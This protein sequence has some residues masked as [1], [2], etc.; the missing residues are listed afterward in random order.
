MLCHRSRTSFE[1]HQI[2]FVTCTSMVCHRARTKLLEIAI[3]LAICISLLR[4][5]SKDFL[6]IIAF[7]ESKINTAGNF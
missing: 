6:K 4:H 3:R 2:I 7:V 5:S 1:R